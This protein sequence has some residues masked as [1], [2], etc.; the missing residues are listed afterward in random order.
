MKK[1]II[2]AV[3]F[4]VGCFAMSAFDEMLNMDMPDWMRER[5]NR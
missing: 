3:G 1:I 2:L 4:I 5:V